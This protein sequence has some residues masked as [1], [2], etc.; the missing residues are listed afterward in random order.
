MHRIFSVAEILGVISRYCDRNTCASCSTVCRAWNS[1]VI[2][3]L[4]SKLESLTPLLRLCPQEFY[5]RT[6]LE[7]EDFNRLAARVRSIR[8]IYHSYQNSVH[9]GLSAYHRNELF[10]NLRTLKCTPDPNCI[11]TFATPKVTS[12][13]LTG[14]DIEP[15]LDMMTHRSKID[16]PALLLSLP[17]IPFQMPF[18]RELFITMPNRVIN[19]AKGRVQRTLPSALSGFKCLETLHICWAWLN[20]QS[21]RVL[22]E[23]PTLASL[24][25][26]TDYEDELSDDS[27]EIEISPHFMGD[28]NVFHEGFP[29]LTALSI[30]F[31]VFHILSSSFPAFSRVKQLKLNEPIVD[32]V[33]AFLQR[34]LEGCPHLHS[35]DILSCQLSEVQNLYPTGPWLTYR[36]DALRRLALEV[37]E[38]IVEEID[39]VNLLTAFPSLEEFDYYNRNS[40][41]SLS[42]LCTIAPFCSRLKTLRLVFGSGTDI[43]AVDWD[44]ILFP[45]LEVL[46]VRN[47]AIEFKDPLPMA[48]FLKSS[49]PPACR[50]EF[51]EKG[52]KKTN[53]NKL[54]ALFAW[55]TVVNLMENIFVSREE[56]RFVI[57][58]RL[59]K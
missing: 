41:P 16:V 57:A 22:S 10:P 49:M 43:P 42:I 39:M 50:L 9:L 19:D 8:I 5:P 45:S 56:R 26:V 48:L 17:F 7:W 47:S 46:D 29:S 35:L 6:P 14:F 27:E 38:A 11:Q 25:I 1:A 37:E 12:F 18:L 13:T 36:W 59:S 33:P 51:S 23:L 2:P 44:H 28:E 21:V 52:L 30:P 54:Y 3:I 53:H 34:T 58:P 32:S 4:W 20:P 31:A 40:L 15:Y 24:E 55:K